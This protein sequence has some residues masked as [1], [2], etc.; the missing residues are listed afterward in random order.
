M[1]D[2]FPTW[3]Q[4]EYLEW[5]R[6]TKGGYLL[7]L[8]RKQVNNWLVARANLIFPATGFPEFQVLEQKTVV[9]KDDALKQ[10]EEW[11]KT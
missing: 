3:N 9:I 7:I 10:L 5:A 2:W 1:D 11:K 6:P 4:P 8:A